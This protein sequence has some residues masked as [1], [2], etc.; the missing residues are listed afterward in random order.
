[1]S[2]P[3]TEVGL[4]YLKIMLVDNYLGFDGVLLFLAR[5]P[6][7]L[8]FLGLC[9]GDSLASTTT[10]SMSRL[11]MNSFLLGSLNSFDC[12][13]ISSIHTQ[14]RKQVLSLM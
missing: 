14:L 10:T 7:F 3:I 13:K 11:E 8:L 5:V 12:I 1:M 4:Q 2:F 9:I 6:V